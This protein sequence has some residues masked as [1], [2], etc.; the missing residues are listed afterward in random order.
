M[1]RRLA[2]AA[3]VSTVIAGLL[4]LLLRLGFDWA[5]VKGDLPTLERAGFALGLVLFAVIAVFTAAA[6]VMTTLASFAGVKAL[7]VATLLLTAV[8]WVLVSPF[9]FLAWTTR[10]FDGTATG[11][12]SGPFY[13]VAV[14][15][16]LL[17]VLGL[18][19]GRR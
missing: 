9:T 18:L 5:E 17:P 2:I 11:V 8:N 10:V 14:I 7:V 3:L 4:L 6:L 16:F 13:A 19:L 12:L 15:L 1:P